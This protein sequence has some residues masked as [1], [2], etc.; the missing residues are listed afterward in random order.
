MKGYWI[1]ELKE[2]MTWHQ[3]LTSTAVS[4]LMQVISMKKNVIYIYITAR[5][6]IS[7][8]ETQTFKNYKSLNAL[9]NATIMQLQFWFFQW[10][11]K[12]KEGN[13]E[14]QTRCCH[15]YVLKK[16]KTIDPSSMLNLLITTRDREARFPFLLE[17]CVALAI[18]LC[19]CHYLKS[20]YS[21][22]Y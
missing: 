7:N 18:L 14:G 4:F 8:C 21:Y 12:Q 13:T 11:A 5:K 6:G 16:K 22:A 15:I 17:K 20:K 9:D 2:T 19:H 10:W 3:I 1:K